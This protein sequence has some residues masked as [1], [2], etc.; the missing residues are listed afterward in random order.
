MP[1]LFSRPKVAGLL[2]ALF[3]G[4]GQ[5]YT[6]HWIKGTACGLGT[7]V[8]DASLGLTQEI[9][10]RLRD[11]RLGMSHPHPEYLLMKM[12]PLLVLAPWSVKDAVQAAKCVM[13][14]SERE[15]LR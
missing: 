11:L 8:L 12:V 14:P 3:P 6:G 7:L 9:V 5:F 15:D 13:P 10:R 1:V 2:S 4:V